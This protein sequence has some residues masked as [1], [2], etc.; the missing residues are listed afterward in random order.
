MGPPN[1]GTFNK[2]KKVWVA[3]SL[4]KKHQS[5]IPGQNLVKQ[6]RD[7]PRHWETA[8]AD[9]LETFG[10]WLPLENFNNAEWIRRQCVEMFL[11]TSAS[12]VREARKKGWQGNKR[13]AMD[14]GQCAG[15]KARGNVS[16]LPNTTYMVVIHRVLNGNHDQTS[17]MQ[18]QASY[19]DVRHCEE[20]ID[21]IET[22]CAPNDPYCLTA[23][24]KCNLMQKKLDEE[25]MG[26]YAPGQM[27]NDSL[28]GQISYN[29]SLSNA[30]KLKLGHHV[31][32]SLI[33]IKAATG[34]DIAE[35]RMRPAKVIPT[36][37]V[38]VNYAHF[39][40]VYLDLGGIWW[41]WKNG[42]WGDRLERD[43]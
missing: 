38:T 36:S 30:F 11:K 34:K 2:W 20:L 27:M 9:F 39:S 6:Q 31:Q 13:P 24:Y 5:I 26:L 25:Y 4:E 17:S 41:K 28:Y 16:E 32:L 3:G 21:F 29:C 18:L 10:K 8:V 40:S 22:N 42:G 33:E 37:L 12:V 14:L 35:H 1:F 15:N 19:T 7:G 43:W 23:L